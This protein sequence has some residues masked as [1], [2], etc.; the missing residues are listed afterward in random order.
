MLESIIEVDQ[1][2]D[3]YKDEYMD[4]KTKIL[5]ENSKKSVLKKIDKSNIQMK[6]KNLNVENTKTKNDSDDQVNK[7]HNDADQSK[8]KE[9]DSND[10]AI[11]PKM[12]K[13]SKYRF[14]K[15]YMRDLYNDCQIIIYSTR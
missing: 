11:S 7:L 10:K 9:K 15:I 4:I 8:G 2:P 12:L 5:S 13:S 1:C 14:L 3:S 6:S